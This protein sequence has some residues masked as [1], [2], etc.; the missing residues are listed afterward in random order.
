MKKQI[1]PET[2]PETQDIPVE[3][4]EVKNKVINKKDYPK[5]W[6]SIQVEKVMGVFPFGTKN[7]SKM[8]IFLDK[9]H[10]KQA[11]ITYFTNI[12]NFP[13]ARKEKETYPDYKLRQRFI[14]ALFNYRHKINNILVM[15]V[16][17]ESMKRVEEE[18]KK[19]ETNIENDKNIK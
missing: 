10:P 5:I 9:V 13:V 7:L 15:Q 14:S 12:E 8:L 11:D 3:V 18:K 19:L 1:K 2:L 6:D 16:I 4:K 17:Q